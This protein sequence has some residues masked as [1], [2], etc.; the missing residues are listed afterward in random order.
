M[1]YRRGITCHISA[2]EVPNPP[3][4]PNADA[5]KWLAIASAH[6]YDTNARPP[7]LTPEQA[8]LAG[9]TMRVLTGRAFGDTEAQAMSAALDGLLFELTGKG[10]SANHDV[11]AW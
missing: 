8:V 6:V 10:F 2:F 5:R 3:L 4:D 9:E 7:G 1:S 11:K